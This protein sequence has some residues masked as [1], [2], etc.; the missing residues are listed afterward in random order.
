MVPSESPSRCCAVINLCYQNE[1]SEPIECTVP[2]PSLPHFLPESSAA[3]AAFADLRC[4]DLKVFC[5]VRDRKWVG[6]ATAIDGLSADTRVLLGHK[7]LNG[8]LCSWR[9]DQAK[10]EPTSPILT[11]S[12]SKKS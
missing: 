3:L 7:S 11:A 6:L 12:P 1:I 10:R 9:T 5:V 8:K 2:A 4:E